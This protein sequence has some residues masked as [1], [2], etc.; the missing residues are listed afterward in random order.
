MRESNKYILAGLLGAGILTGALVSDRHKH[1][2]YQTVRK[3]ML[4]ELGAAE[5]KANSLDHKVNDCVKMVKD[6]RAVYAEHKAAS[7][8]AGILRIRY[9]LF[10]INHNASEWEPAIGASALL[11]SFGGLG[12]GLYTRK[13]EKNKP[14]VEI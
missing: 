14:K 7:A 12:L 3:E 11:L 1:N 6:C 9:A 5:D 2:E 10:E 8:E 4:Q 13:R